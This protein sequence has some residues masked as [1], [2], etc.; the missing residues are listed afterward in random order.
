MAE[1]VCKKHG[2]Y[3]SSYGECPYCS[4][5]NQ[6]TRGKRPEA[7]R[8]LDEDDMP[9]DL[10]RQGMA[11]YRA[12]DEEPTDPPRGGRSQGYEEDDIPT[13]LGPARREKFLDVDDEEETGLGRFG[14]GDDET[15]LDQL[16]TGLMGILWVKEGRRRGKIYP[17]KDGTE[18][19]RRDAH[20][21]LDDSKVS[22]KHA[23]F[24][25]VNEQFR[26]T[27]FDSKNG[28]LVNGQRI[29]APTLLN[30]NDTIKIGETTFV[31]KVLP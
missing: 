28:T 21:I 26:L 25:I 1:L 31:L 8:P 20:L 7:P 11:G 27:D 14:R 19:G 6:P 18:V 30:E 4:G 22:S 13:D 10:P 29:E 2:P 12:G 15:E 3:D 23:R 5:A 24:R 16:P 17:I 9:T